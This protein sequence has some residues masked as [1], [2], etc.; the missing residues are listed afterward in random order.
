MGA[1]EIQSSQHNR[2]P[3]QKKKGSQTHKILEET[4]K[5]EKRDGPRNLAVTEPRRSR[6]PPL[7]EAELRWPGG[8]GLTLANFHSSA[9]GVF[10]FDSA[11]IGRLF[12][13]SPFYA[14][15]MGHIGTSN[16]ICFVFLFYFFKNVF[17][18][19]FLGGGGGQ[20]YQ[21]KW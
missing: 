11:G 18:A 15:K 16:I 20:D 2:W 7:A 4:H 14:V 6:L 3:S 1:T 9:N 8:L 13:F 12:I 21:E 17:F 5:T 19:H 10:E